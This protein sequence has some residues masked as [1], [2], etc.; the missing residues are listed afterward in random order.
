DRECTRLEEENQR[1]SEEASQIDERL[2]ALFE[3]RRALEQQVATQRE[4]SDQ[5]SVELRRLS[6]EI[7]INTRERNE[8][9]NRLQSLELRRSQQQMHL[10]RCDEEAGEKFQAPMADILSE[11]QEALEDPEALRREASEMRQRLEAMGPVNVI[12]IE[13]YQ[14]LREREEFL[15]AQ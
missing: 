3:E 10:S 2:A 4:E 9:Q 14:Q 15:S 12:A 11:C 8:Q 6:H 7:H 13:E 5:A 1:A